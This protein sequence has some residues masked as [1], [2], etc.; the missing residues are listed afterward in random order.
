[1]Y[2]GKLCYSQE[3]EDVLI[4]RIL[5]NIN[6]SGSYID[7]GAHHPIK[8]SNTYKFYCA[9]W[10]GINIEATPGSS[11]LFN[12][13]RP[14]DINIE[15]PVFDKEEELIFYM[16]NQP[17][18]NTFSKEHAKQWDGK[19]DIRIIEK[20]KLRTSILNKIIESTYPNSKVFDMLSID[21]EGLDLRILKTVNFEKYNFNFVIIEDDVTMDGISSSQIFEFLYSK[22]YKLQSKLFLSSIYYFDYSS[23]PG[24]KYL[25]RLGID[26]AP[27]LL[28]MSTSASRI[29]DSVVEI[30]DVLNKD[31][32][33]ILVD[34]GEWAIGNKL[35]T[36][37]VLP[38]LEKEGQYWGPPSTDDEAITELERQRKS[39]VASI[40]FAWP[41]FWWLGYFKGMTEYLNQSCKKILQNDRI[42]V[43]KF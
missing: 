36:R 19:G 29:I 9:G 25:E 40:V 20:R 1:M 4:E 21:V 3:G 26:V 24:Q 23:A 15:A 16:F 31:K 37:K 35:G 34:Q 32:P 11:S 41:S 7:V 30:N 2:E 27:E 12:K 28:T 13:V 43:Y 39:G 8:L 5:H 38:F 33:I 17:E 10:R 6:Y 22:G 14:H 18:L 42:I